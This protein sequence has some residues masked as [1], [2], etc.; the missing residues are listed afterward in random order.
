ME[1]CGRGETGSIWSNHGAALDRCRGCCKCRTARR[2]VRAGLGATGAGG[3]YFSHSIGSGVGATRPT[4]G[5]KLQQVRQGSN[6]GDPEAGD[7]MQHRKFGSPT[8]RSAV[9]TETPTLRSGSVNTSPSMSSFARDSTPNPALP[10]RDA[11]KDNSNVR[12]LAVAVMSALAPARFTV[13]QRQMARRQGGIPSVAAAQRS[14]SPRA[15]FG[16]AN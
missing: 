1:A 13:A 10:N 8:A 7:P 15:G 5:L 14:Q 11:A 6:S 3:L 2:G 12:E 4:L 9:Q 16:N